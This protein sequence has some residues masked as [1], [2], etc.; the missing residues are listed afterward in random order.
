MIL[1]AGMLADTSDARQVVPVR[2]HG[3]DGITL[4]A[5]RLLHISP[6]PR[7]DQ[8]RH[9]AQQQDTRPHIIVVVAFPVAPALDRQHGGTLAQDGVF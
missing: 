7:I 2:L 3:P 4:G 1:H 5:E 6:D 8:D 9:S